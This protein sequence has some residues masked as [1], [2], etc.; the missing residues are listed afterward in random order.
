M[1]RDH[2]LF[3][4]LPAERTTIIATE[5]EPFAHNGFSVVSPQPVGDD[6]GFAATEP[7]SPP[8]MCNVPAL[9]LSAFAGD[10]ADTQRVAELLYRVALAPN[11]PIPGLD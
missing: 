1:R 8:W 6:N 10:G 3:P 7:F 5:P 9:P 11:E 4:R 2:D